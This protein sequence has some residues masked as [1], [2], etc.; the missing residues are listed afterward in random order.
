[1][2]AQPFALADSR[3][4]SSILTDYNLKI[5]ASSDVNAS[6]IPKDISFGNKHYFDEAIDIMVDLVLKKA[7]SNSR[8]R[9]DTDIT[10][11]FGNSATSF[12]LGISRHRVRLKI[13]YRF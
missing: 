8:L 7:K 1:M 11:H 6:G 10:R 12:G 4:Y 13:K 5:I 9:N 2:C 3:S